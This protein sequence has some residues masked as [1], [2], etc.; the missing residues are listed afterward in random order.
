MAQHD[1]EEAE[2]EE[3]VEEEVEEAAAEEV[4]EDTSLDWILSC[5][6]LETGHFVLGW[7]CPNR[8][9]PLTKEEYLLSRKLLRWGN[10]E[11]GMMKNQPDWR[12]EEIRRL[13]EKCSV[14]LPQALSLRRHH[15]KQLNITKSMSSLGLGKEEDIRESA[16][17]F[18][19]AISD[20]LSSQ[21]VPFYSEQQQRSHIRQNLNGRPYP[22]TPDFLLHREII[23]QK[24]YFSKDQNGGQQGS[25]R[26]FKNRRISGTK[27]SV[28]WIDAKMFYGAS[29]V[30]LHED[31]TAVGSLLSTA[32]KYNNVYGPGAFVFMY[33]YGDRLAQ[34]LQEEE[35]V[36][37]L[38]C[39]DN[40][41]S[42]E[43][44]RQHQQ[45]W[46]AD[47]DGAIWP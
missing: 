33:G 10:K 22:P 2:T 23:I 45:T 31:R 18:E 20:F 44:V 39:S 38:D 28:C 47:P 40:R 46:C 27:H 12:R 17:L 4:A 26:P 5:E 13:C 16:R 11:R 1:S 24:Y 7:Y 3:E 32:R 19:Q 21:G 8:P 25:P 43:Q 36:M 30:D 9:T 35:G 29:S 37:A 15:M 6:R 14:P 42:L 41:I 34:L